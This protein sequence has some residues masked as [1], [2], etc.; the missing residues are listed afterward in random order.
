MGQDEGWL[1]D[2][3]F[4]VPSPTT[5]GVCPGC[6]ARRGFREECSPQGSDICCGQQALGK[7]GNTAVA[8]GATEGSPMALMLCMMLML[9]T[10]CQAVAALP[11]EL[12]PGPDLQG[13]C[14][15]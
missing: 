4:H 5:L 7:V 11:G 3:L 10:L 14:G 2:T 8:L 6:Q 12:S 15:R 13:L 1:G 9:E